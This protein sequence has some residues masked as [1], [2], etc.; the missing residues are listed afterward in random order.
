MNSQPLYRSGL[1]SNMG[2]D[3]MTQAFS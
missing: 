1:C 2:D 3:E